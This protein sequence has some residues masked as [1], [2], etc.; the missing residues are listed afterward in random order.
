VLDISKN[1]IERAKERL[2]N[3]ASK[4]YWIVCDVIEFTPPV[5]FDF[6]PDRAA[7]HFLTTEE[8]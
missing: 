1:A 2:G 4:V 3:K 5:L 6:W 7:F 8:R